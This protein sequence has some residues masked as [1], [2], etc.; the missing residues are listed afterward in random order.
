MDEITV[1]IK[2][3]FSKL[4]GITFFSPDKLSRGDRT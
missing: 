4:F 1:F 2:T 3:N